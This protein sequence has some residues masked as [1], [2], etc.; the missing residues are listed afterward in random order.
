[1]FRN[2]IYLL[3]NVLAALTIPRPDK[4]GMMCKN[5]ENG[6]ENGSSRFKVSTKKKMNALRLSRNMGCKWIRCL[7][8]TWTN[9]KIL[10][11]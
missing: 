11:K 8:W 5:G 7:E 6:Y 3:G 9:Q 4:I 2:C 1:M 10:W